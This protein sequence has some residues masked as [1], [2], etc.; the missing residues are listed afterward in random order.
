MHIN[1]I[2]KGYL[3]FY[4]GLENFKFQLGLFHSSSHELL[5]ISSLERRNSFW[6]IINF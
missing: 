5:D 1:T 3:R 2:L 4:R 6:I